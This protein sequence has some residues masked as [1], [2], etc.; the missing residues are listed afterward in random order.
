MDIKLIILQACLLLSTASII[1][2]GNQKASKYQQDLLKLAA[3]VFVV[4]LGYILIFRART[5][6]M[7]IL[8]YR[9]MYAGCFFYYFALQ[10][11]SDICE[12]KIPKALRMIMAAIVVFNSAISLSF[13]KHHFFFRDWEFAY[14]A[15]GYCRMLTVKGPGTAI[16]NCGC[17]IMAI[18]S[19]AVVLVKIRN[20]S[21]IR[22]KQ[23]ILLVIIA[24]LAPL[25]F[26]YELLTAD[27]I[28]VPVAYTL[29]QIV[30]A[31]LVRMTGLY[32]VDD[33][34]RAEAFKGMDDAIIVFDKKMNYR[35]AN[36]L[37]ISFFPDLKR[38][39]QKE[40]ITKDDFPVLLQLMTRELPEY[41]R[42]ER[43][44]E[45]TVKDVEDRRDLNVLWLRDVTAQRRNEAMMKNYQQKLET[46]VEAQTL[47]IA[48]IQSKVIRDMADI[49]ENRDNN[50]G[51][52]VKRTSYV[53]QLL[54]NA[55]LED[56]YPGVSTEFGR[57]VAG[58]AP[59]HDIGKISIPDSIL[60]KPGKLS[61]EEF[62]VM[63]S[64]SGKG[65]EMVA[66]LLEEVEMPMVI[67][68]SEN[69]ARHHHEKWDGN[70]YPD[71]LRNEE[72]PLEARIMALADVYDALVSKRCYKEPMSFEK[73]YEIIDSGFG[74]Q[75]DPS[76]K[77]YFDIC[78]EAIEEFYSMS[79]SD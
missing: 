26:V 49:I 60:Q 23:A 39:S 2:I 7:A 10:F 30:L 52:H 13:D 16:Y 72:I 15:D 28:A 64:H 32:D 14:T 11:Y 40:L 6:E 24:F 8:A 79:L 78:R 56:E 61:D 74:T 65:A 29:G 38:I 36:P 57:I 59:L 18:L 54:T 19:V 53:V 1:F 76:L 70:G 44:F 34:I 9:L 3:T 69:I 71:H 50:T 22:R 5:E 47:R 48:S 66:K 37:A 12:Y 31:Y 25:G 33:V 35:G 20:V 45:A 62:A 51:G 77:K 73:A 4:V 17:I 63:K 41:Q 21:K 75:F 43:I 27:G 58:T 68:I 67:D 46:E 42:G 55:L